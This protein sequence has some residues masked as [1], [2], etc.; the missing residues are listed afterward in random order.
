MVIQIDTRQKMNKKHHVAKEQFF[1]DQGI[2]VV[3][4]KCLVGDYVNP[5]NSKVSVDTK[6]NLQE[7]VA[8]L[9][10]DHE[11]FR[12]EADLAAECGIKLYILVE[13]KNMHCLED[14]KKWENPRLH[15]YNKIKYMHK[16]GKWG[17]IPEPKGKPP[18][19]NITLYK[20]MSTFAKRHGVEWVFCSTDQAGKKIVDL[21][22]V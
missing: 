20:I 18:V 7:V 13:E 2:K 17:S 21:L 8:D 10:Q 16:L 9:I 12:R 19:D 6:Q 22:A 5:S 4:S 11:R 1:V 15:R 14:V 3:H